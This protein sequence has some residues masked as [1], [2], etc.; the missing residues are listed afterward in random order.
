VNQL[1]SAHGIGIRAGGNYEVS[2]EIVTPINLFGY[3]FVGRLALGGVFVGRPELV[4]GGE[5]LGEAFGG[6]RFE[7]GHRRVGIGRREFG[8]DEA[9][10]QPG[11]R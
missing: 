10:L 7:M 5:G 11:H 3:R 6:K 9:R 8:G 2:L 4:D 1:R